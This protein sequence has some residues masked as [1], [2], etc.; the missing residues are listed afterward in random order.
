VRSM[1]SKLSF[2]HFM[3][4]I[5]LLFPCSDGVVVHPMNYVSVER[6]GVLSVSWYPPNLADDEGDNVDALLPQLLDIADKYSLKVSDV[7]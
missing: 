3:S 6:L 1:S 2:F 4:V 7:T 5:L